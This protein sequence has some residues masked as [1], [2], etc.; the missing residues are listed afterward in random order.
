M[1]LIVPAKQN[2]HLKPSSGIVIS[3]FYKKQ[4][5]KLK[6]NL[7]KKVQGSNAPY[8]RI[9]LFLYKFPLNVTGH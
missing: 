7:R 4:K 2:E 5:S 1:Q 6:K 8:F 3:A 9:H